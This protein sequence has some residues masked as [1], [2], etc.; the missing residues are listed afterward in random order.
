MPLDLLKFL[1]FIVVGY[2]FCGF[3]VWW[4][5]TVRV[6]CSTHLLFP[7]VLVF[8]LCIVDTSK[9]YGSM[10]PIDLSPPFVFIFKRMY[11]EVKWDAQRNVAQLLNLTK[12]N[13]M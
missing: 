9:L 7:P 11:S 2:K 8:R 6:G 12:R 4:L 13:L 5:H 10:F 3:Q 1:Y